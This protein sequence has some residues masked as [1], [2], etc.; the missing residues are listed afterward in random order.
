M[1]I[2]N[3]ELCELIGSFGVT[4]EVGV[5]WSRVCRDWWQWWDTPRVRWNVCAGWNQEWEVIFISQGDTPESEMVSS[6]LNR[7]VQ[8][9]EWKHLDHLVTLGWLSKSR[10]L[11][12][13]IR[14]SRENWECSETL[15]LT[16]SHLQMN[17]EE[18][19]E[20]EDQN[21]ECDVGSL[22]KHLL[23]DE[24]LLEE[25]FTPSA[26]KDMI[27]QQIPLNA[28]YWPALYQKISSLTT[29]TQYHYFPIPLGNPS[30]VIRV[31]L[32]GNVK[33]LNLLVDRFAEFQ[34]S[35]TKDSP[36]TR[37][38][39]DALK[40]FSCDC[41][42]INYGF[43]MKKIYCLES[44]K[45]ILVEEEE[46]GEWLKNQNLLLRFI[47]SQ[48]TSH[49]VHM[50]LSLFLGWTRHCCRQFMLKGNESRRAGREVSLIRF[51]ERYV[52]NHLNYLHSF[53]IDDYREEWFAFPLLHQQLAKT[54]TRELVVVMFPA[55]AGHPYQLSSHLSL[56]ATKNHSLLQHVLKFLDTSSTPL[57]W[58]QIK[59]II[60][61]SEQMDHQ[62]LLDLIPPSVSREKREKV[63][64]LRPELRREDEVK[65]GE[66]KWCPMCCYVSEHRRNP[67][68]NW[69]AKLRRYQVLQEDFEVR[70]WCCLEGVRK[71]LLFTHNYRLPWFGL[72]LRMGIRCLDLP[73]AERCCQ[74][75]TDQTHQESLARLKKLTTY[76]LGSEVGHLQCWMHLK[77]WVMDFDHKL[78]EKISH[79][80][81]THMTV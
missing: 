14:M 9:N 31:A 26:L 11:R 47:F 51:F 17:R 23:L 62:K 74:Y 37:I 15:S 27:L 50:N 40:N 44:E 68:D 22:P 32:S 58:Q 55:T 63:R 16:W 20:K 77:K 69:K 6:L 5:N 10:L 28:C 79:Q 33:L 48:R 8:E 76:Y 72:A 38:L 80:T 45:T 24:G 1:S 25:P 67:Q 60:R 66:R 61:H 71:T 30:F 49:R 41:E 2:W 7:A 35:D 19:E 73:A 64:N 75:Q 36:R 3:F 78:E 12:E 29:S 56:L 21:Y 52:V 70:G 43:L 39:S 46:E 57:Q 54:L 81:H 13:A 18:E 4:R 59:W 53:G 34:F 65:K 42:Y